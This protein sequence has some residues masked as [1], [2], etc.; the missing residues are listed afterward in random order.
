MAMRLKVGDT[1]SL[2]E[3]PKGGQRVG[4][5][6]SVHG[7]VAVVACGGVNLSFLVSDGSQVDL[8]ARQ[9]RTYRL[10][11]KMCEDDE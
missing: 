9:K 6:K 7:D 3:S 1:V 4:N 10:L 11:G 8:D 2:Q 5:V